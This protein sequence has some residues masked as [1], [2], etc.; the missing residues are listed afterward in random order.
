MIFFFDQDSGMRATCLVAL[1]KKVAAR[2]CDAF[3]VR[4]VKRHPDLRAKAT[5]S[6]TQLL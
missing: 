1:Q 2:T 6:F 4:I 5:P 3:Y